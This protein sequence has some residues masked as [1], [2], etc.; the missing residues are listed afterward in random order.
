[1]SITF[2]S[3][4]KT[5][6]TNRIRSRFEAHCVSNLKHA[7]ELSHLTQI[8]HVKTAPE[9]PDEAPSLLKKTI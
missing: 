2:E 1:M 6:M 3:K 8:G 4:G 9:P 7:I 5:C